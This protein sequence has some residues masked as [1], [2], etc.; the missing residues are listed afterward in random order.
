MI[1]T[2]SPPSQPRAPFRIRTNR[3]TRGTMR[4]DW[5]GQAHPLGSMRFGW[6]R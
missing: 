5:T 6:P 4:R 2:N 1:G 3:T